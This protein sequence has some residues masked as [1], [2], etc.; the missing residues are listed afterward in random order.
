MGRQREMGTCGSIGLLLKL[1]RKSKF[2]CWL[3]TRVAI[4]NNDVLY[5][6]K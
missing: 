2:W 4:D 5:I 1:G 6:S 3:Y